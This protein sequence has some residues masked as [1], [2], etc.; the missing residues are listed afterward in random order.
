MNY[1]NKKY[2]NTKKCIFN[3]LTKAQRYK[4]LIRFA[5]LSQ[6]VP[7][8]NPINSYSVNE[9]QNQSFT[10][11]QHNQSDILQVNNA[12][13][14]RVFWPTS[15]QAHTLNTLKL[16]WK[17]HQPSFWVMKWPVTTVLLTQAAMDDVDCA[18]TCWK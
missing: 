13:A 11:N 10:R 1:P 8:I 7:Y 3:S 9:P 14:L 18:W 2:W 17:F 4:E 16:L 6:I 15:V 12:C 5:I